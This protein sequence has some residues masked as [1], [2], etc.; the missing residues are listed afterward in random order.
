MNLAFLISAHI[1]PEHLKRLIES[2]PDSSVY[3]V[4]IDKKSDLSSFTNLIQSEN[5]HFIE[6][7]V[8]VRWGTITEVDYQ[9][10]L[11]EAA[12]KYPKHFDRIIF[13]S[14]LDYPIWSND[15]LLTYL[16]ENIDREIL[17]GSPLIKELAGPEQF[18]LY[19]TI[20]PF[21]NIPFLGNTLNQKLSIAF[22][23][24]LKSMGFKK[25][26]HFDI[27]GKRWIIYKG[28]AWWCISEGLAQY[29]FD[30]YNNY[31]AIRRYFKHQFCPAE[32]LIQTISFNAPNYKDKCSLFDAPYQ[33]LAPLTPL[34][35][36]DYGKQ[37]KILTEEDF[38]KIMNSGKAF[39]RKFRTGV[40]DKL[41]EII[42]SIRAQ[43]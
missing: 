39:A 21:I 26:I 1:D 7:R 13:I 14:G 43:N 27:D 41:M 33:G 4:H 20:R 32:T 16:K 24:V 34:H 5:V 31:P 25:N 29:V 15:H 19:S 22:R 12:V 28:G 2:L 11:I 30:T 42:D 35:Y 23:I 8:N 38:E 37:I 18:D 40:S 10:N 3:F 17:V 6:N 9:M 36:I